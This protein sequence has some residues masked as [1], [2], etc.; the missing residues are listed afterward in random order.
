MRKTLKA[1][2]KTAYELKHPDNPWWKKALWVLPFV[3]VAGI[4]VL[5]W[6]LRQRKIAH[7][8]AKVEALERK[9]RAEKD[10]ARSEENA[11]MS[12]THYAKAKKLQSRAKKLRGDTDDMVMEYLEEDVAIKSAGDWE[13]LRGIYEDMD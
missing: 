13:S 9:A 6:Y 8:E 7:Y 5:V 3:A 11:E 4:A 2:L 12:N 1:F 10:L